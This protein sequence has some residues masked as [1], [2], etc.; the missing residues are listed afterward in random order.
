MTRETAWGLN[1]TSKFDRSPGHYAKLRDEG[2][3]VAAEWLKNWRSLG[4]A[5]AAYPYDARYPEPA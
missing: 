4:E 5:F 2:Q 3:A 1:H